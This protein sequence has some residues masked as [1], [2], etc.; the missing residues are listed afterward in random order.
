M[1]SAARPT[2]AVP[3]LGVDDL[4]PADPSQRIAE[5]IRSFEEINLIGAPPQDSPYF[6]A[7]ILNFVFGH[8]W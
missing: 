7:G 4:G 1:R 5:G 3:L 8:L 2:A 6:Y